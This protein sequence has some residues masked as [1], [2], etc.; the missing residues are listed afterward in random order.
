[1][2]ETRRSPRLL[3]GAPSED[4][5]DHF[6]SGASWG[7]P[8]TI[9]VD[10]TGRSLPAPTLVWSSEPRLVEAHAG[11][12]LLEDFL[13]LENAKDEAILEYARR[14]GP[15]WLCGHVLPFAHEDRCWVVHEVEYRD[16]DPSRSVVWWQEGL[17]GWRTVAH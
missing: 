8:T 4:V 12:G 9:R 5:L 16:G 6:V 15:L 14:W 10:A 7:V 3:R 2:M 11:P 17:A 13:K 1:M